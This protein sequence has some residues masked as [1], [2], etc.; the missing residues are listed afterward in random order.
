MLSTKLSF[1][2]NNLQ[3]GHVYPYTVYAYY[4]FSEA[5]KV[6]NKIT[7][8]K[9][10]YNDTKVTMVEKTK[11]ACEKFKT[12]KDAVKVKV[13]GLCDLWLACNSRG[14]GE[15]VCIQ[16]IFCMLSKSRQT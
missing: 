1:L 7:T 2:I 9:G 4:H 10:H 13:A 6:V 12:M 11:D 3:T 5:K 14:K 8:V 15:G 16:S